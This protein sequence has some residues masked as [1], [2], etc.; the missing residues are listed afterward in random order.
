MPVPV[1]HF[2]TL[3]DLLTEYL[4]TPE[5]WRPI[6]RV[7]MQ[8]RAETRNG[9]YGGSKSYTINVF[10][11]AVHEGQI[12]SYVAYDQKLAID[13]LSDKEKV[14]TDYDL[15]WRQAK[16]VKEE[17]IAYLNHEGY[18][19]RSGIL[20]MGSTQPVPGERWQLAQLV[21]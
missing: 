13:A 9:A 3:A 7:A 1:I 20:D 4:D 16:A 21:A 15:Y 14:R 5:S 11:R 17:I 2:E 10:V 12:L 18:E 6:I 8:Q 19:V